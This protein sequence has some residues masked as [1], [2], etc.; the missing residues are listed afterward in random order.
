MRTLADALD[1]RKNSLNA[2]RLALAIGVI[3][4][5]SF[6]L[7]GSDLHFAPLRQLVSEVFVDAFFAISGYLITSSWLRNPKWWPFI[8]SRFLR[9]MP[10]FWC[11]LVVTAFVFAPLSFVLLSHGLPTGFGRSAVGYLT[12]NA[13]LRIN[14]YPIAGSPVSVPYPRAWNGSLWTL[15]WEVM[16]YL[17]V[18]IAGV[19]RFF[20]F[21][22]TIPTLFGA[23]LA[24]NIVLMVH[25]SSND[26]VSHLFRFS[27]MFL[28]GA[29]L[30]HYQGKVS[31]S[32]RF[33]A[34]AA[35]IVAVSSLL[36]DYRIIGALPVAYVCIATGALA[37]RPSLRNDISYGVYVYA[38]P[39]Q[40]MLAV[41][42]VWKVGMPLFFVIA[43][44]ATLPFAAASWFW[45]EKPSLRLKNFNLAQVRPTRKVVTSSPS[46]IVEP[47]GK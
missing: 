26:D 29:V 12:K 9:I 37:K 18:L 4:W 21:A 2:I 17:A 23:S 1:P 15:R 33:V 43:T 34:I 16:C 6:P 44:I 35:V 30:L 27:L 39:V 42:G 22:A 24:G 3:A 20:R 45:V 7:T 28:A 11:N 38:F 19:L 41:L 40:Q 46:T 32:W 5:H 10:G 25:P 13:F 8:R 47:T 31:A 36:P 14:Q